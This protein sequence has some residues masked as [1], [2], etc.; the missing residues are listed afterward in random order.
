MKDCRLEHPAARRTGGDTIGLP[1]AALCATGSP[2][3]ET[4]AVRERHPGSGDRKPADAVRPRQSRGA[5]GFAQRKKSFMP[6]A[7][8][9][10][11]WSA[12]TAFAPMIQLYRDFRKYKVDDESAAEN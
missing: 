9:P 12:C 6:N 3:A 5:G 10:K 7:M 11:L 4:G 2:A 8:Q 1:Q